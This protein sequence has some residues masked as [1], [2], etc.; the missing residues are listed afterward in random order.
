M[1]RLFLK[2]SCRTGGQ[3]KDPAPRPLPTLNPNI[4][5]GG[6][7]FPWIRAMFD[8]KCQLR[9]STFIPQCIFLKPQDSLEEP[10]VDNPQ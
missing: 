5:P 1:H 9:I 6:Q 7:F 4:S 2:H 8:L 3:C 10:E